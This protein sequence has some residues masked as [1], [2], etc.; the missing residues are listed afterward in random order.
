MWCNPAC[1]VTLIQIVNTQLEWW[2]IKLICLQIHF[3]S[4]PFK[5]G[6][7]EIN[8]FGTGSIGV[9]GLPDDSTPSAA[10]EPEQSLTCKCKPANATKS[11]Q[12]TITTSG[13]SA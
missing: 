1:K 3:W 7:I 5:L 9:D 2:S 13:K 10:I 11:E 8:R 6:G 12:S 4:G